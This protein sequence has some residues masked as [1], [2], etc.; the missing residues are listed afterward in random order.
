MKSSRLIVSSCA[1]TTVVPT[2]VRSSSL[3]KS[4]LFI[5]VRRK[6]RRHKRRMLAWVGIG[7]PNPRLCRDVYHTPGGRIMPAV[8]GTARSGDLLGVLSGG[9]VCTLGVAPSTKLLFAFGLLFAA[10]PSGHVRKIVAS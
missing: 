5:L 9:L 1:K 3:N 7:S 10:G 2:R 8:L 6:P 4:L